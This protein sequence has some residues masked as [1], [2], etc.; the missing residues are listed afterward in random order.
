MVVLTL[1]ISLLATFPD[2]S[3]LKSRNKKSFVSFIFR[4]PNRSP[5]F[6]S[7][8]SI[9]FGSFAETCAF[10]SRGFNSLT[11]V[12]TSPKREILPVPAEITIK[13]SPSSPLIENTSFAK[14]STL[15]VVETLSLSWLITEKPSPSSVS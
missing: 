13:S 2:N 7:K 3:H 6:I 8:I 1:K 14:D 15:A 10:N 5:D 12:F 9:C 4:E 11:L